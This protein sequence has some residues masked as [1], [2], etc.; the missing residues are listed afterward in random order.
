MGQKWVI[1]GYVG[2]I[3]GL[4]RGII[5]MMEQQ[6]EKNAGNDMEIECMNGFIGTVGLEIIPN[7]ILRSS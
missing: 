6:M 2:V 3:Q 5:P 7:T 4:F 1:K